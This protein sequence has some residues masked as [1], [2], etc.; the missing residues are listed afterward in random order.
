MVQKGSAYQLVLLLREGYT[1]SLLALGADLPPL[2]LHRVNAA[3]E[4]AGNV[5]VAHALP[6]QLAQLPVIHVSHLSN[7]NMLTILT[8]SSLSS[9]HAFRSPRTC[10]ACFLRSCSLA[11]LLHLVFNAALLLFGIL[12]ATCV[13]LSLSP[14]RCTYVRNVI[15]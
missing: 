13:Q 4:A 2:V 1:L 10:S 9:S 14:L 6:L 5:L 12:S 11:I 8:C 7:T 15:S 3:P